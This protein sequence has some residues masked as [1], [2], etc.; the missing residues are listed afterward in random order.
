M[1]R[2]LGGRLKIRKWTETDEGNVRL[3][4]A[5]RGADETFRA[6]SP[7]EQKKREAE[8][9]TMVGGRDVTISPDPDRA[10]R[11]YLTIHRYPPEPEPYPPDPV[12]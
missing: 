1:A 12:P 5:I 11:G 3:A 10:D 7:V 6:L 9:A 4:V 2:A 8:Y